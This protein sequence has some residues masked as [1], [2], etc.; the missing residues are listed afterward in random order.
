MRILYAAYARMPTEKAHGIQ[1]ASMCDA[2]ARV[3]ETVTLAVPRRPNHLAEDLFSYYGLQKRFACVSVPIPFAKVKGRVRF[4]LGEIAF[5]LAL[6]R[7][8]DVRADIVFTRSAWVTFFLGSRFPTFFEIHNF[9]IRFHFLWRVLLRRAAGFVSTNRWKAGRLEELLRLP[10]GSVCVA[11]NG[12][13][14]DSFSMQEEVDDIRTAH[15]LPKGPL[16]LYTG[17]VYGW[18]G[19]A[20]LAHVA[21]SMPGVSFV[22]VGGTDRDVE[23]FRVEHSGIANIILVPHLKRERIPSYLRAA[24]VLV[25]P[26]SASTEESRHGT[27]PIKLFEYMASGSPIVASDLPSIREIVDEHHVRFFTPDD[28]HSLRTAIEDVLQHRE[29]ARVR[30]QAARVHAQGYTWEVRAQNIAAYM[31]RT[32]IIAPATP[33]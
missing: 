27:S 19:T 10:P 29:E 3:G 2:F 4:V 23:R 24:D 25:L 32:G 28:A 16:V 33:I 5:A 11:P 26:N 9:P 15:H 8:T 20:L 14:A 7:S 31:K 17:N 18:K 22:F 6:K 30:A 21:R 13:A 1:I 12:Y